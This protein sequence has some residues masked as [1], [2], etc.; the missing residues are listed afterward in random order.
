MMVFAAAGVKKK[1]PAVM[2]IETRSTFG[3]RAMTANYI[4]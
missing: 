1:D 4:S 3:R 2:E